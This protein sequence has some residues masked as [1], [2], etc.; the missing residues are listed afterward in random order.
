MKKDNFKIPK[1]YQERFEAL[2]QA[3][4]LI[5]ECKYLLYFAN[6]WGF[7]DEPLCYCVPVRSKKEALEYL[8]MAVKEEN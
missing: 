2:E 8:K 7:D 5:D 6:G 1:K 4:D 3:N